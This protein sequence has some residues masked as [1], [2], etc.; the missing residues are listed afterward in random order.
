M[1]DIKRSGY[2]ALVGRPNV[3][4]STLLN[5]LLGQKVA[6]V[7]PRPQTTRNKVMGILTEGD[8][9]VVFLDTP[10]L[11]QPRTKLGQSMMKAAGSAMGEVDLLVMVAEPGG[12]IG[13]AEEKLIE[14]LPELHCP[15]FLVVNKIDT[16][17]KPRLAAAIELYAK[18]YAFDE[19][20]PISAKSGDG[21]E[22]VK[23][24]LLGKMP[25]GPAYYP[26][27]MVTDQPERQMAAEIVREKALELLEE[28]VP[29]GI[30]VEIVSY[31]EKE[32]GAAVISVN[33]YCEKD[34][35]KGI[36]IGKNGARLKEISTRARLELEKLLDRKVFLE[37]WVRVKEDWRDSDFM[38]KN[39]GYYNK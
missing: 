30:A 2:V 21:V 34:S 23:R 13:P 26:E 36:V 22:I 19:I 1:S 8:A 38:L 7:S 39:F 20:I 16:V 29:H 11:H 5:A 35:H 32:N 17:D 14:R 28:E 3:G 10:G 4:K 15:V 12:R 31:K 18:A 33:I 37:C 24:L 9:Q 6:I 25:E 27:D